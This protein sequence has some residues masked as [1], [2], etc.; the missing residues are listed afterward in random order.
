M[1]NTCGPPERLD[2]NAIWLPPGL[3]V[4]EP[5]MAGVVGQAGLDAPLVSIV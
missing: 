3:Q 2:T 4:G 5:S 1:R